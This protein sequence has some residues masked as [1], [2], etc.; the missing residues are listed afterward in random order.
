MSPRDFPGRPRHPRAR[1]RHRGSDDA[2]ERDDAAARR[3]RHRGDRAA[4]R[5]ASRSA[6]S[7]CRRSCST[8]CSGCSRSCAWATVGTHRAGARRGRHRGGARHAGARAADRGRVIGLAL[9]VLQVPLGAAIYALMGASAEVTRAARTYFADPHLVGAVRAVELRAVR[10]ARRARP[11]A[12][13]ARRSRS[14]I[15]VTNAIA[16]TALL[17]LSLGVRRAGRGHRRR[18]PPKRSAPLAGLDRVCASPAR[19]LPEPARADSTAPRL[20]RLLRGQPRHLHPHRAAHR[21]VRRFFAAQG[22]RQGDVVLAAN[23]VLHN[24]MLVGAF[25][26]DGFASAAEQLCGRAVGAREAASFRRSARISVGWGFGFGAATTAARCC[27]G[28]VA[29]RPDDGEPGCA[30]SW[31]AAISSMRRSRR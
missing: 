29:D 11:P 28:A 9:I 19:S 16:I 24:L 25:F 26:L 12:N 21:R 20:I 2:R 1:A 6:R 27:S 10:L 5:S 8:A 30:A 23:S 17:V 18:S 7:R 13:G 31:R 3:G 4:R 15:N 22:A 14:L